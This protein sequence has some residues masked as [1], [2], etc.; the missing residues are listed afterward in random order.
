[1]SKSWIERFG[2]SCLMIHRTVR[3]AVSCNRACNSRSNIIGYYHNNICNHLINKYTTSTIKYCD[4]NNINH[5]FKDN[6]LDHDLSNLDMN[7]EMNDNA[8]TYSNTNNVNRTGSSSSSTSSLI[9]NKINK[10]NKIIK[11]NKMNRVISIENHDNNDDKESTNVEIWD[12]VPPENKNISTIISQQ[13]QRDNNMNTNYIIPRI[14]GAL[15]KPEEVQLYLTSQGAEKCIV[16]NINGFAEFKYFVIATGR[17][18][19]HIRKMSE[20]IVSTVSIVN[21]VYEEGIV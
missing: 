12:W 11:T 18:V 20:S 10:S 2:S 4:N 5:T 17:S 16:L 14:E 13:Q 21:T 7:T 15:L 6:H 1:M 9:T 3:V 8:D 19:R